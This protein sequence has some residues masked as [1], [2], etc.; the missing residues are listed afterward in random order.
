M[1]Q[2]FV[3]EEFEKGTFYHKTLK[4]QKY[5]KDYLRYD[6]ALARLNKPLDFT[7]YVSPACLPTTEE[8]SPAEGQRKVFTYLYLVMVLSIDLFC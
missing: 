4:Q 1:V 5:N 8:M 7:A 2:V 3:N 6:L